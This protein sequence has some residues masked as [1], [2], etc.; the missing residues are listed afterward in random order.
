MCAYAC[1]NDEL[2]PMHVCVYA[3]MHMHVLRS[4]AIKKKKTK[5]PTPFQSDRITSNHHSS[6]TILPSCNDI[7]ILTA[8]RVRKWSAHSFV[9]RTVNSAFPQNSNGIVSACA[10]ACEEKKCLEINARESRH[11]VMTH[12]N[13]SHPTPQQGLGLPW[14]LIARTI[15]HEN[16]FFLPS[17]KMNHGPN[18]GR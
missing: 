12:G 18:A 1:I 9:S 3:C 5:E 14:W 10:S 11:I 6:I 8:A 7:K 16:L 17:R 2:P 13:A 4:T 15:Q